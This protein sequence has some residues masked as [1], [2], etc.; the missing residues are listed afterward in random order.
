MKERTAVLS[1][2]RKEKK[3][4]KIYLVAA[5]LLPEYIKEKPGELSISNSECVF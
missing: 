3:N 5:F 1:V 2:S 4:K